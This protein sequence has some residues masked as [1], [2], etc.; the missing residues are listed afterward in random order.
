LKYKNSSK[1]YLKT[2]EILVDVSAVTDHAITINH[3]TDWD[4]AK[5]IDRESNKM[6]RCIKE[7]IYIRKEQ[8]RSM[9]RD[10]G[11]YQLSH[12]YDKLF[13]AVATSSSEWKSIMSFRRRQQ[14]LLKRQQ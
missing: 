8:E 6:D 1:N 14:P 7:A 9:N 12:V 3:V 13:A 2:S 11:S 4:Q 10:D 5:M